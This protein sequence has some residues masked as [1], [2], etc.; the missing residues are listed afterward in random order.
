MYRRILLCMRSKGMMPRAGAV[1][2][3]SKWMLFLSKWKVTACHLRKLQPNSPEK[4][5]ACEFPAHHHAENKGAPV[6]AWPVQ[7]CVPH[8]N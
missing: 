5:F 1:V 8:Y 4:G 2:E 6:P 7:F 3:M